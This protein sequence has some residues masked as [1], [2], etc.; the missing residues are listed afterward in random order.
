MPPAI[1]VSH[2]GK[3]EFLGEEGSFIFKAR[4]KSVYLFGMETHGG[5]KRG[6]RRSR[7]AD[8]DLE[9]KTIKFDFKNLREGGIRFWTRVWLRFLP[10][11]G[12][13]RLSRELGIDP[14]VAENAQRIFKDTKRIDIVPSTSGVRG[15]QLI[16][17]RATSLYFYQDGDHFVYDGFESGDYEKGDVTVFDT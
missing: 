4:G 12:V 13:R 17:D 3:F 5:K 6:A 16:I 9:G 10:V 8:L 15:F 7:N 11:Y 14:A 1:I 2:E